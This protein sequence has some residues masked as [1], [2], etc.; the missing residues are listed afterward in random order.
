MIFTRKKNPPDLK[1]FLNGSLLQQCNS[2]KYLG[3][4][5]DNKLNWKEH[6]EYIVKKISKSCGA[7]AK[8]RHCVDIKTLINVYYALVNS[9]VRYGIMVWGSAS[10][11]VLKPLQTIINKAIRIITFAPFGNLDLNP[12]YKQ[13]KLLTLEKTYAF[14]LAKFTF[15]ETNNLLPTEIGNFFD[16][17]SNQHNHEHF[18][19]NR[20]RPIRFLCNSKIGEKSVQYNSFELR[21]KIPLTILSCTSL[22]SFK[23]N[24]KKFLL[25]S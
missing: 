16:F 8:L 4:Y 11:T 3:V 21:K 17:S 12:A 6:V 9:Y 10:K 18:V 2:Y 20:E 19:R 24:Y 23:K 7:L 13:L 1:I 25:D 15:K 14:E 22:N 5:F